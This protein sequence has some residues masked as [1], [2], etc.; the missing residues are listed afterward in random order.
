[1]S[2]SVRPAR[3]ARIARIAVITD[4]G[5]RRNRRAEGAISVGG[6]TRAAG[7]A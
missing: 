4:A 6:L 5:R 3:I 1:M 7:G 2:G